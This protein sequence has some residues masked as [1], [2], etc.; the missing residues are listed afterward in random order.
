MRALL[1]ALRGNA[2]A[3][4]PREA[5]FEDAVVQTFFGRR[6]FILNRPDAIH[7]VLVD[8]ARNYAKAEA[9][10]RILRPM[11]GRGLFLSS[12]EDW[13]QQRRTVAGGFAP[14]AVRLLA[15]NVAESLAEL[16]EELTRH[17]G[18][19]LDLVPVFQTLA[20][21]IIGRAIFS[22]DMKRHAP[23]L[24]ELILNY[25]AR[26][27]RPSLADFVLPV[28][29]PTPGDLGRRRFRRRWRRLVTQ[30][31]TERRAARGEATGDGPPGDLFDVLAVAAQE[32]ERPIERLGDQVATFIVAGH[33]TTASA[34]FWACYLLA[35]H[36]QV[37][38]RIAAEAQGFSL[39]VED[40]AET[41][42]QLTYTRAVVDEVLRL[43]P[44]AFVI[45]R[46]AAVDDFVAGIP[47]PRRSL[48]LIAP[49]V[50]HRHR[51]FWND[52]DRFDPER[53]MP[54]RPPPS[55]FAYLPFGTGPRTC[56]G[57]AFALT[58]LVLVLAI[59]MRTFR[60]SLAPHEPVNPV[61][62]TTVQPD[63][64]PPFLL[65]RR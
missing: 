16:T 41:V 44:P 27:G 4:F 21:E 51:R 63:R 30:I 49:W 24:R 12:G 29:V 39:T 6:H 22:L 47:V 17:E 40:A 19:P 11:L 46:Q 7:H 14:R 32:D 2:L 57:S 35:S 56:I 42:P 64:P 28:G 45:T 23:E 65:Q 26:L 15:G 3:A 5:F 25:A 55:R 20:L 53:F 37:Q 58:E 61:G 60:I 59:L 33:E 36:P 52:P 62:L 48:I 8:Q 10:A 38:E 34:M 54:D 9:A 43:Y 31:I 1:D 50:I 13:R 18:R